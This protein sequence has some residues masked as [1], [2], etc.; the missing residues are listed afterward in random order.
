MAFPILSFALPFT[1]Y[2]I[3]IND[4]LSVLL[5]PSGR[6]N[7]ID[8]ASSIIPK[9]LSSISFTN[10]GIMPALIA[11]DLFVWFKQRLNSAVI[12]SFL[13]HMVPLL[14][15]FTK[16]GIPFRDPIKF[17]FSPNI[18]KLNNVVALFSLASLI[19]FC[20][21]SIIF[22]IAPSLAIS[23]LFMRLNVK[24]AR[25]PR[26]RFLGKLV[27]VCPALHVKHQLSILSRYLKYWMV[28]YG[29][30][31]S[32]LGHVSSDE[33]ELQM[34]DGSL[35]LLIAYQVVHWLRELFALYDMPQVEGSPFPCSI[36]FCINLL[37]VLKLRPGTSDSID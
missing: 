35:E 11:L 18:D 9:L 28:F 1:S 34:R 4:K 19:P 37:V 17:L 26:C 23:L 8:R 7:N 30:L 24:M 15:N 21:I 27:V 31:T 33:R 20:K 25:N 29:L 10:V 6:S 14:N 22:G 36:I 2:A 12:A 3:L 13:P 32:I 16:G 5:L